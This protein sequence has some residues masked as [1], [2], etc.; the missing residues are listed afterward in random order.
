MVPLY[1]F[2]RA[3]KSHLFSN[4]FYS[5]RYFNHTQPTPTL[6]FKPYD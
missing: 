5:I 4:P 1:Y 6:P 2:D 3:D